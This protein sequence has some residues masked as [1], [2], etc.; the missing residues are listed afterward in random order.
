M[1][2][3]EVR[4]LRLR[5]DTKDGPLQVLDEISFKLEAGETL[6]MV[7]ES[8]SGKS[9]TALTLMGLLP[10][11]AIIETGEVLL[12]GRNL[13]TLSARQWRSV[14]GREL[15]MVYQDANSALH[16]L[17]TVGEQLAEA[18]LAHRKESPS[19]VRKACASALGEVGISAPEARLDAYPH[20]LSGGMRQRVVIAMALL[21]RPKVLIADEPTTAVDVTM[22]AQILELLEHLRAKYSMAVLLVTHDL[23]VVAR[24][25]QKVAVVYAGRTVELATTK[26]LFQTPLHPYSVGLLRSAPSEAAQSMASVLAASPSQGPTQSPSQAPARLFS[27][28]GMAPSPARMPVGCAFHPRCPFEVARCSRERP[29]LKAWRVEVPSNMH[30]GLVT[31]TSRR[32]ACFE[33]ERVAAAAVASRTGWHELEQLWLAKMEPRT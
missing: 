9:L 16:P 3:L 28:P 12:E 15:A 33:Q 1:T 4:N 30:T 27:I 14:R 13:L 11:G 10:P 6:A 21:A 2:L 17:L 29:E 24:A 23:G 25:A 20:E 32:A 19:E 26:E 31:A 18:I 5:F 7:G 22:Q 8:G